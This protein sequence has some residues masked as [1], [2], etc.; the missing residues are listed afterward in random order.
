MSFTGPGVREDLY[1]VEATFVGTDGQKAKFIFDKMTGG[2]VKAQSK[3]YRPANGTEDEL[4][5]GGAQTVSNIMLTRLYET[6]IDGW[7]LWLLSQVGKGTMYVAKQPLDL[8]GTAFGTALRYKGLIEGVTPPPTDSESENP[9]VIEI[10]MSAV[11]PI[12]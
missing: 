8:N 2:D 3:K 10:E 6:D 7:V 5:L 1:D 9:A 12:S 11:T 4:N